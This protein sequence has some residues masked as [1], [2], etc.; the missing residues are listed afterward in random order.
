M[1][2]ADYRLQ[3]KVCRLQTTDYRLQTADCRLQT[4]GCRLRTTVTSFL[5][6]KHSLKKLGRV[7]RNIGKY[8]TVHPNRAVSLSEFSFFK[9]TGCRLQTIDCRLQRRYKTQ[10][11][12]K[13]CFSVK[14]VITCHFTTYLVLHNRFFLVIFDENLARF[15]IDS[16]RFFNKVSRSF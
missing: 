12:D 1:Q 15:F 10:T 4:T 9:T 6:C 5:S 3:C 8:I 16:F 14:Y 13:D 7:W 11:E 2:T